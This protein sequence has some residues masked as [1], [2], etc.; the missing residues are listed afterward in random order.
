VLVTT[1]WALIERRSGSAIAF[2][3]ELLSTAAATLA[4]RRRSNTGSN[5]PRRLGLLRGYR[6]WQC[7]GSFPRTRG[8]D[9]TRAHDL[10]RE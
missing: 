10:T 6:F 1:G 8:G 5:T 2:T 7:P 3:G 9:V 4:L